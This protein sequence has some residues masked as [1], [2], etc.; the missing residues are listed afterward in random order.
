MRRY[1]HGYLIAH[2]S[3]RLITRIDEI[4]LQGTGLARAQLTVG[5][6]GRESDSSWDLAADIHHLDLRLA[7]ENGEWRVTRAGWQAQR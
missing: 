1:L 4:E 5:M 2:Q 6:L 3:L 7:L